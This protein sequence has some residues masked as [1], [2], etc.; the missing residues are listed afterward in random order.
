MAGF[1]CLILVAVFVF[2]VPLKGDIF[3]LCLTGLLYVSASTGFGLLLSSFTRTQIAALAGT[4]I[5]TLLATVNFS[6]MTEPVSSLEGMGRIIGDNWPASSFIIIVRGV[7]TKGLGYGDLA[8]E[9]RHLVIFAPAFTLLSLL[10]LEKQE[11]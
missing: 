8:R 6:G 2:S 3:F 5:I 9:F 10:L 7:F 4:A 11:K 1:L